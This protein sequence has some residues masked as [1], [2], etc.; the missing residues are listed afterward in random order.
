MRALV[1]DDHIILRKGVIRLL[2]QVYGNELLF[3]EASNG[4]EA[5]A[6]MRNYDFNFALMDISM[7]G[8]SGIDVLK[9]M[10][11]ERIKIP[12][13]IL[14]MQPEEQYAIRAF[15][16]GAKGYLNKDC[17]PDELAIAVSNIL[18][19][20]N[21]VAPSIAGLMADF[22]TGKS[23]SQDLNDLSDRELQVL[24]LLAKGKT[25]TQIAEEIALSVNTVSTYRGRILKK[26][27][28]DNNAALIKYALENKIELL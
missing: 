3:N 13:I 26:L 20:K 28:L 15:K 4:S 7:P 11:S 23:S 9:Q 21:Y 19:G 8:M 16:A 14:T 5:I 18:N 10:H 22:M 6:L 2:Q 17:S 12:V 24:Q 25:L 27:N 1:V